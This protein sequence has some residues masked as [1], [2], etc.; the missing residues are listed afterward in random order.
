MQPTMCQFIASR[1][2]TTRVD[3]ALPDWRAGGAFLGVWVLVHRCEGGLQREQGP[4]W[5]KGR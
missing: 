2:A 1:P 4:E 5:G 3:G